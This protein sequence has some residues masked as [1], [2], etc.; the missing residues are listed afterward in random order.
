MIFVLKGELIFKYYEKLKY[1]IKKI[2]YNEFFG[3]F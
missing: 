1:E 3:K 2:N